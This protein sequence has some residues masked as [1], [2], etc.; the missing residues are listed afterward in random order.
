MTK[1]P[2]AYVAPNAGFSMVELLIALVIGAVIM[3]IGLPIV[4]GAIER[5]RLEGQARTLAVLAGQARAVAITNNV[6][7]VLLFDG[8]DFVS[9]ADRD[10]ATAADP[11][12]GVFNPVTGAEYKTTDWEVG[13]QPLD[14]GLSLAAP[15]AQQA[16]D[17]FDYTGAPEARPNG[18]AIFE[19]D[20]SLIV[21][22]AFRLADRRGNF[23]EVSL[24]PLATGK[25]T[26]RKWNG[27]AW[28]EQGEGDV[29]WDWK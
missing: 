23:L 17:G 2:R 29:S 1:T 12:D 26:V 15:G 11:P 28:R 22:G 8:T 9:F 19:P 21:T 18:R 13:R 14:G 24:E 5:A 16:I 25:V 20:G 6:E 10:G 7:T 4:H 3:T 27:S